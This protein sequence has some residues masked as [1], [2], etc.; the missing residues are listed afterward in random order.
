MEAATAAVQYER[1]KQFDLAARFWH[2]AEELALKLVNQ[3]WAASRAG[4]CEKLHITPKT[5]P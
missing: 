1:T 5:Q 3:E 2:Q 4:L